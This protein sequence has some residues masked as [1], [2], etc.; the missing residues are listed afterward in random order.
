MLRKGREIEMSDELPRISVRNAGLNLSMRHEII[1][2][3]A[4]V[5]VTNSQQVIHFP[6]NHR[7]CT[8]WF[9]WMKGDGY[10]MSARSFKFLHAR[11]QPQW[12]EGIESKCN[13]PERE[14][15]SQRS[16]NVWLVK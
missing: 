3:R 2:I 16:L 13:L 12:R 7:V 6:Y 11:Q 15:V 1:L 5:Q 10:V 14:I 8:L 4:M 9:C